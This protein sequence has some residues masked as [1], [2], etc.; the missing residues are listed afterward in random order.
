MQTKKG[1]ILTVCIA[2]AA[3]WARTD[4]AE[5]QVNAMMQKG[6][7]SLEWGL[8]LEAEG[9]YSATG[10]RQESDLVLAAAEF[11]VDAAANEWLGGHVGLLWEEDVTE[12]IDL[13]E[14]YI[15]IGTSYFV[16]AGKF[17]LPFGHFES[18][19]ISDP[20]ALELAE[21]NQ[22]SVMAGCTL[23]QL[24]LS[25]G[26]FRGENG[27]TVEN[28]YAAAGLALGGFVHAGIYWISD[29]TETSTQTELVQEAAAAGG[30]VEKQGGAGAYANLYLG[31]VT[32]YA[33]YV[34]A[35]DEVET[36]TGISGVPAAYT[37][38]ASVELFEQWTAGLKA[39]G[40]DDLFSWDA[41]AGA[42]AAFHETGYGALISYAF[43]SHAALGLEYLRMQPAGENDDDTDQVTLQL[44]FEI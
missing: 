43:H 30:F 21:I 22:S 42:P 13:D 9:F 17:Y 39:E 15:T 36:S 3:A 14:A 31:P 23:R 27:D 1:V 18:A 5:E 10:D 40:S 41:E 38:E 19:F 34:S 7:E 28:A 8:L 35:L 33:E 4:A 11:T 20:L 32:V 25:A 16:R 12:P 29:I 26:A 2:A 37:L 44:A 24:E 6:I